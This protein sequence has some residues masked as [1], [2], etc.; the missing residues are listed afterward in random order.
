MPHVELPQAEFKVVMLGDT[1]TGKTSLVLRFA[2]GHFRPNARAPTVG[3]FFI[4]K[5]LQVS[6]MTCKIQIWDTAGQAQFQRMGKMYYQTAAAVLICYDTTSRSSYDCMKLWIEEVQRNISAGS[7]VICIVATKC[8]LAAS[9]VSNEEVETLAYAMGAMFMETSAKMDTNVTKLFRKVTERVLEYQQGGKQ[10]I[11]VT[12]GAKV[13][14]GRVVKG[15]GDEPVAMPPLSSSHS[16][17][18]TA[19]NTPSKKKQQQHKLQQ[20][21]DKRTKERELEEQASNMCQPNLMMCG[22]MPAHQTAN[23]CII[24]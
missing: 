24:L 10:R 17:S 1:N 5:R 3:A 8:D 18:T 11:P 22:I 12:P 16:T 23:F 19:T 6:N 20:R 14:D 13:Q 4:T 21:R 15:N 2:E 9:V 7:I